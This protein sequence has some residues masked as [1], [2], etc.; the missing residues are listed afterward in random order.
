MT[1]LNDRIWGPDLTL[2]GSDNYY[3]QCKLLRADFS[4]CKIFPS[5]VDN[6]LAGSKDTLLCLKFDKNVGLSGTQIAKAV[7]NYGQNVQM[8]SI[9][10]PA[11]SESEFDQKGGCVLTGICLLES[12]DFLSLSRS[13]A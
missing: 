9:L 6:I 8:L 4:H 2:P 13:K 12:Q 3:P 1:R 5:Q 7:N 11:E 10:L